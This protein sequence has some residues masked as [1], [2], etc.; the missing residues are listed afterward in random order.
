M[1]LPEEF[2]QLAREVNNWGRWGD[3][4]EIG[5]LNL[6][7]D[8]VVRDAASLI[9]TGKRFPLGVGLS[10]RSPQIGNIPG[11][12]NPTRTMTAINE[13]ALGDPSL[14]CWSEDVVFMSLQA[15]THWDALA[16]VSYDGRIYNDHGA[17]SVDAT[18]AR[19]CGID[20]VRTLVSRG[21]LLDVARARGVEQLAAGDV[22]TAQDLDAAVEMAGLAVQPGDVV[23]IRTGWI[24]HYLGGDRRSYALGA[25]GPGMQTVRWFREH[26]VAA[27]ATD[28]L[29]FEVFPLE[30][31][32]VV[33]PVHLLDLVEIGLTQGQNFDLEQ[34]ADDCADDGVYAFFLEASPEPF[35]RGLGSPVNPVAIK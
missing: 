2:H 10:D 27:V 23:L 24:R 12:V 11:R 8:E 16:H 18:G 30:R 7:T 14:Y 34:L 26:D 17:S 25:P 9:R 4:D 1:P 21:V 13:P 35:V 5:T 20:K 29:A 31:D 22:V 33:M 28:T 15:A 19:R 6:V 32:D 3:D